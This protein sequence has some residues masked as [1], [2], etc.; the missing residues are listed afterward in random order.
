VAVAGSVTDRI[1]QRLSFEEA[2]ALPLAG[3]TALQA[4]RRARLA[5][6][7]HLLVNGAAGGVGS[8]AVQLG[9]ALGADVTGVCSAEGASLVTNL[10]ARVID[11]TKGELDKS[12]ARFDVIL[13]TV[14]NHP[15]EALLRLLARAGR[16]VTTGFSLQLLVR[17][18]LGRATSGQHFGFVISKADGD[19]MRS[20]SAKVAGGRLNPV[21]DTVFPLDDIVAA[22]ERVERGHLR[23][24]VVVR[25]Q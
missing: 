3:M 8:I 23:G 18:V 21:V 16:Y 9:R 14:F 5:A 7:Q 20:L 10:G 15:P 6:G 24:K 25:I 19:L 4:L 11:Y 22:H 13:H 2:A 17:S 1:P 12:T